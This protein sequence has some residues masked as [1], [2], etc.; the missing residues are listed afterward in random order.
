MGQRSHRK[1]ENTADSGLP[2]TP[3]WKVSQC[4][5]IRTRG[6][7]CQSCSGS[8]TQR[9]QKTKYSQGD[10][11]QHIQ[12]D[13]MSPAGLQQDGREHQHGRERLLGPGLL[14]QRRRKTRV[15]SMERHLTEANTHS[16]LRKKQSVDLTPKHWKRH[17][18]I[19][20]T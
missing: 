3:F 20:F 17:T 9:P 4:S 1:A 13:G 8:S 7:S 15:I 19:P 16:G 5:A 2:Q 12:K 11:K 18:G 6:F 10:S 14:S